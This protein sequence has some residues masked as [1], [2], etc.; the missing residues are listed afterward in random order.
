[1]PSSVT[2]PIGVAVSHDEHP[3]LGL[4]EQNLVRRHPRLA[5]GN[6]RQV[7]LHADAAPRGHLGRGR[8]ESRRA[9]VLDRDDVAGGD[10]FEARLQQ[11][12]LREWIADLHLR[13][14]PL[15][16][17]CQ[18]L[19]GKRGAVDAVSSG[20]GAE[21]E[22][23]V[24]HAMR[25]RRDQVLLPEQADTHRVD[26]WVA[27]VARAEVHLAP[28]RGHA[29][30]VAVVALIERSEAQAVEQRHRPGAH[31]E[32]VAQNAADAGRGPLIGLDRGGVVMG[33]NFE[34]DRP[35]ARQPQH[36][37]VLA[38]PLDDLRAGRGER[39]ENGLGVLVRAMLA[40]QRGEHAQLGE[41]G[42][43]T[44]HRFDA[45]VLLV[46]QIVVADQLRRDRR[47]AREGGGRRHV[48]DAFAPETPRSTARNTRAIMF[49]S[50]WA[51][52]VSAS[53]ASNQMPWQ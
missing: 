44:Q 27:A 45:L 51:S 16:L 14:A 28:Q 46:G 29:D 30:A 37:G 33:L 20:A 7:D 47:V 17:L 3:L 19:G 8:R 12:L 31:R 32:H 24:A 5:R 48:S 52:A 49:G 38:G 15:A 2:R 9:H 43:A 53:P 21:H 26:E 42:R 35:P 34:G 11:Q 22:Q 50:G 40:P 25:R 41:A 10:Q 4:G 23:R 39:F 6:A 36:S 18:L 1:M 13:T